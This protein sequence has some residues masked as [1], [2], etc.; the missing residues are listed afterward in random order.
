M[1]WYIRSSVIFLVTFH[2]AFAQKNGIDFRKIDSLNGKPIGK[3]NAIAQSPDGFLWFA[4]SGDNNQGLYRYDGHNLI[5]FKYQVGNPNSI[6]EGN[7]ETIY[8]DRKGLIWIGLADLEKYNPVSGVFTHY[9]HNEKDSNSLSGFVAVILKDHKGTLWVGTEN[10]LDRLDE[11]TGKFT[12]FRNVPG[13]PRSLSSNTVRTLYE[14]RKGVLWIGT[15]WPY[16][17]DNDEKRK[18][19]GL[20]RMEP[21]GTFT[22]FRHDPANPNSLINNKVT[23]LFEDSRGTFWVGTNGDGLHTMDREKGTFERLSF[24]SKHPEKLS[25]P[26]VKPLNAWADNIRV[27]CED[28]SHYIWIGTLSEGLTRYDPETKTV[29]RYNMGNGFPDSS[30][31]SGYVSSD[32]NLWVSTEWSNTLIQANPSIKPV[33]DVPTGVVVF[34]FLEDKYGDLW[35]GTWGGGL[36]HF[37]KDKKFIHQYKQDTTSVSGLFSETV[38]SLYQDPKED[39]IW[40]GTRLGLGIYN[41]IT[42][43][44][45]RVPMN[46]IKFEGDLMLISIIK[47]HQNFFWISTFGSGLI[48]YNP[49][50]GSAKQFMHDEK[51][52]GSISGQ[53]VIKVLEDRDQNIWVTNIREGMGI[54]RLDKQTGR[55][56]HYLK[57]IGCP[58][59]FQDQE[60]ELWASTDHGGL[61]RYNKSSNKFLPFFDAQS[62]LNGESVS[63]IVEDGE[64]N[65]WLST[66]LSVVKINAARNRFFLYDGRFGVPND[67]L[68]FNGIYFTRKGEILMGN[69]NGFYAFYPKDLDVN[70]DSLRI[71]ITN[72]NIITNQSSYGK[73]SV[74]KKDINNLNELNLTYDQNTFGFKFLAI[75]Y[76]SPAA[77]KYYTMLENYDP[78]WREPGSESSSNYFN[79]IPGDYIFRVKAFSGNGIMGERKIRVHISPPWWKTGWAYSLYGLL[80]VAVV[81]AFIRLQKQQVIRKERHRTQER[82]LVQAKEI[83]KAYTE[84]KATQNQ[85]IQSEKMAS[86]GELTA[87]IAHEIQNPLNFVNNFS[88]VNMEL[89]T[90]MRSELLQMDLKSTDKNLLEGFINDLTQNEEKINHHGRRADAIVKG[91]LQHSRISSGKKEPADINQLADE[92]LR[93]AYHG[94]RAKDKSFNVALK[95]AYDE[96]IGKINIVPQDIGRVLLNFYNNAFYTVS[97]KKQLTGQGYEPTVEVSTKKAAGNIEIRV[98]DNGNGIQI[99]VLDKIFQPFFTT[100]PAGQGTGLGLSISFD[101]VKAHGG[102]IKVDTTEGEYT[103]FMISLPV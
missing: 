16:D 100:K 78:V 48:R 11:E 81:L 90:E 95:T 59:I 71:V 62:E 99:K 24:D 97:E 98:K 60:G 26:A 29:T 87:G 56:Q 73:D 50:D 27:I 28:S 103:R 83:E 12:H 13:N 52:S 89:A 76:Q 67:K 7:L 61:Y 46:G 20:N 74:G 64:R 22:R 94:L 38:F 1:K 18:E 37:D 3:I 47:D 17:E 79:V 72:F 5:R 34:R 32:G 80:L 88:E 75:D 39:T 49:R 10:G 41:T 84:L 43:K 40:L 69:K 19:G 86:L 4:G 92:Y 25:R 82:E 45:S 53:T 33:T 21:D 55:F 101:I 57:G 65:L 14:D 36:F 44:F 6:G 91:M 42:G 85:L 8:A 68:A 2:A 9:R 66:S 15:G 51:D 30:A 54:N 102:E 63:G 96:S 31:Y 58:F 70:M 23:A 93:L 77:I 35:V